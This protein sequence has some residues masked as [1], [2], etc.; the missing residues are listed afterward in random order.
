MQR[1]PQFL[2]EPAAARIPVG[3]VLRQRGGQHRVDR[4]GYSDAP[5]ARGRRIGVD[6]RVHQGLA[7]VRTERRCAAEELEPG[8]RQRIL[9]GP[10]VGGAALDL[11]GREV[12]EHPGGLIRRDDLPG[13]E[14]R[15]RPEIGEVR[16]AARGP[17]PRFVAVQEDVGWPDIPV[18]HAV[19][20][21][22][23]QGRRDLGDY[24]PGIAER[25]RAVLAEQRP[26]VPAGHIVHGNIQNPVRL[27]S[28][29][30]RDDVRVAQRGGG[31]GFADHPGPEGGVAGQLRRHHL[32]RD[33][34]AQ[35]LVLGEVDDGPAA[36]PD[37]PVQPVT[38]DRAGLPRRGHPGTGS[39]A[40]RGP[41]GPG[42][43]GQQI[44]LAIP[45]GPARHQIQ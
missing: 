23:V 22:G 37:V 27:T 32:E 38:G 28:P 13:G 43:I 19:R 31:P 7:L 26:R 6:L 4:R 3:R 41:T 9:I 10:A 1:G 45:A 14:G 35:P 30:D 39:V 34:A 15:A 18:D 33:P 36:L 44:R 42:T 40:H 2:G 21:R 20:V 17:V 8:T 29:E 11:L 24:P 16:M 25:K 5:R 12:V